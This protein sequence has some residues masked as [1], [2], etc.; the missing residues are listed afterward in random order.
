MELMGMQSSK[1]VEEFKE[2]V[3]HWQ[4][5]LKTV[6]SVIQIWNKTQSNWKRLQPI[7]CASEDI[8]A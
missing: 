1:D 4:F 6:D 2:K 3:T 7:F 5:N 8:R